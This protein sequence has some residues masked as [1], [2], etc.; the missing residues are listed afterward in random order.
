MVAKLGVVA[1]EADE[2]VYWI[3]LLVESGQ[4][5]MAKVKDLIAEASEILA[6]T[7]AS[8]KTLRKRA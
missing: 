6:M 5:P 2:T 3:E 8:I 1:E 4:V 7:V